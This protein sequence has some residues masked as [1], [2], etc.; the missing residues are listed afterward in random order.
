MISNVLRNDDNDCR[1]GGDDKDD[2]IY[3]GGGRGI[4]QNIRAASA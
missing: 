2:D 3:G 4:T 1:Y